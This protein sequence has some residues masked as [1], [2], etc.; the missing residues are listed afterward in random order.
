MQITRTKINTSKKTNKKLIHISDIHFY[1]NYPM[2][3]LSNIV[4]L[5]KDEKPDFVCITGDILDKPDIPKLEEISK[6]IEFYKTISSLAKI[7]VILGN[8]DLSSNPIKEYNR[9]LDTLKDIKNLYL[10]RNEK[11][12][13][14]DIT[15]LSYESEKHYYR[16]EEQKL[17]QIEE[18]LI[19][20]LPKPSLGQ[21]NV[22]LTHSP[23]TIIKLKDR[24]YLKDYDLFLC[25]H[26][27][28]GLL[29]LFL[30]KNTNIHYG[31]ISPTKTMFPREVRGIYNGS[32]KIII[33]GGIVKFSKTSY[34]FQKFDFLY[35]SS[36]NVI[37]INEKL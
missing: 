28:D 5:I 12:D 14:D 6:Y 4:N 11:Q 1:K 17:N 29:P 2:K 30:S 37:E 13:F 20:K 9:F 3:K 8:H 10:L 32:P 25:G 33:N 34:L 21:Y 16:K 24:L 26:T 22:V 31:I 23:I 36:A 27:H 35:P 19:K 7:I 18:D 15:F